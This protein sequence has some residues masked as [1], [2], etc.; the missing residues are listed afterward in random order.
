MIINITNISVAE[1]AWPVL[2]KQI[3]SFRPRHAGEVFAL[4]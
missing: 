1:R 3:N 2:R 4:Y